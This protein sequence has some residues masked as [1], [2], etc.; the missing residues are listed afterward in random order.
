MPEDTVV[1]R[2]NRYDFAP[3]GNLRRTPQGGLVVD[4]NLSRVGVF[5]YQMPDGSVRREYRP[6]D[7]VFNP[8]S[9]NS[10]AHAPVTDEHPGRVDTTN[11]KAVAT[12]YV[13]GA[14]GRKDRFLAGTLHIQHADTIAKIEV[15]KLC[16]LSCGYECRVEPTPG[17]TQDGEEYDAIQRDIRGN[18]VALGPKGWGRAGPE[19]RL[20]LDGGVEVLTETEGV[21]VVATTTQEDTSYL[22]DMDETLKAAV[23]KAEADLAKA[24]ADLVKAREDSAKAVSD[25][26]RTKTEAASAKAE[27]ATVRA[28]NE[29]LKLQAKRDSDEKT[30]AASKAKREAEIDETIKVRGDALKHISADWKHDGKDIPAIKREVVAK[31]EPDMKVDGLEGAALDAVYALALSHAERADSSRA[32]AQVAAAGVRTDK[33]GGDGDDDGPAAKAR[34][35]MEDRKRDASKGPSRRDRARGRGDKMGGDNKPIVG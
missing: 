7:E 10:F 6:Q 11:W 3:M 33:M 8:D 15:G 34:K 27:L 24:N 2:V 17:V 22:R 31:L 29:V 4:A 13:A 25:A 21:T 28:E 20:H 12:G 5:K 1:T 19:V 32:S 35:G 14:P 30:S 26:E 23:A 16:E 9:M 18:H